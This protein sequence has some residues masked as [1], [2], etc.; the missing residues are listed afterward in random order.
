[1][2]IDTPF[3]ADHQLDQLAGQFEH[4]R[5][6][7][8]HPGERIPQ[9]LWDQAVALARVLPRSRVAQHL[10]L[11][12]Q[13]PEKA[14]G[15]AGSSAPCGACRTTPGFVEV[16]TCHPHCSPARSRHRG[17]TATPRWRPAAPSR[18]RATRPGR[19]RAEL[20]GGLI[21]LQLT[22]QSRIFL[23]TEPVDFRKGIDGLGAVCRQR[24][25]RK[26]AGGRRLRL[27]K[28]LGHRP[29]TLAL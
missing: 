18:A 25:G 19:H 14:D 7:R 6:T 11:V 22:P 17:R 27:P 28:P 24:L 9:A 5:Q 12:A 23:A 8:S 1:M 2:K 4:W 16:P 10:R 20:F 3:H 13:R 29:Q 21:M 15:D 26:P